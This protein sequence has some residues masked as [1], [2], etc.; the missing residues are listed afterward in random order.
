M[1][2]PIV[3]FPSFPAALLRGLI[4]FIVA[5][6]ARK[7]KRHPQKKCPGFAGA[8]ASESMFQEKESGAGKTG[9]V[10]LYRCVARKERHGI[11]GKGGQFHG[12]PAGFGAQYGYQRFAV[13]APQKEK[14][15][16]GRIHEA[17]YRYRRRTAG[18]ICG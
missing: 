6:S 13:V 3:Y 17:L 2:L 18:R 12:R 10:P 8:Q 4:T 14:R 15:F 5:K 9:A 7:V 1:I 16:F 11:P